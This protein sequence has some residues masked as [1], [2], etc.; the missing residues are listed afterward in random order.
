[1]RS[2]NKKNLE[3]RKLICSQITSQVANK[4]KSNCNWSWR[5]FKF[6]KLIE[7]KQYALAYLI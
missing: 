7:A 2:F 1:M 4:K 6:G 3:T 5:N